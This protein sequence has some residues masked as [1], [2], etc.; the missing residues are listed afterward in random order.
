M[1]T[2]KKNGG[3]GGRPRFVNV[4]I[5]NPSRRM[6]DFPAFRL[7]LALTLLAALCTAACAVPIGPG[8]RLQTR[9]MVLGQ[10]VTQP[11]PVHLRVTDRMLNSGNRALDFLDVSLPVALVSGQGNLI[12]QVDGKTVAPVPLGDDPES[13]LRVRFDP[14]WPVRQ[15]R[16]IVLEYDL[17]TGPFG[18]GVAAATPEG[19]YLANPRALPFW[20]TPVGV[21]AKGDLLTREERFELSLPSDFRL[22]ASGKQKGRR[23][24][25]GKTVYRFQTTGQDLPAF[26]IAGRYQQQSIQAPDGNLLFWTFQPLDSAAARTAAGR[27]TSSVGTFIRL[28]GPLPQFGPLLIVEAPPGLL[29]PNSVGQDVSVASFPA[30]LL[31][32][33]GAFEQGIASESVLRA[34]EAA[35]VRIWFGWRIRL[36]PDA[37][38]LLGRGLGLYGVALAAQ[39]RGGESARHQEIARLLAEYDRVS[40]T[41]DS[42]SLLQAPAE[43]TPQ[44]LAASSRKAALFLAALDDLTGSDKFD[45]SLLRLQSAIGGRGLE[46]SLDDLR[47]S[48]ENST[49]TALGDEFRVWLNHPGIPDDFRARY[50]TDPA[51]AILRPLPATASLVPGQDFSVPRISR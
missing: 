29:P 26:V 20:V 33:A 49:D 10:S 19:F 30:G 32:G 38:I 13:P 37:E 44:Q 43:S 22:L 7:P 50:A 16:D 23:S 8:F 45:R 51:P 24:S 27:L 31:L 25:D 18:S 42:E 4:L 36:R 15:A 47:A 11:A 2:Y 12:M 14:P 40:V 9:Q 6:R 46:L 39:T 21:F 3:V 41:G 5:L 1:N 28:F 35:L 34:V 17:A 48:L